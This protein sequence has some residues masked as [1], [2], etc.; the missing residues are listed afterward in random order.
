MTIKP[1]KV[2][3][4]KVIGLNILTEKEPEPLYQMTQPQNTREYKKMTCTVDSG[5]GESVT[6]EED[7]AGVETVP[8]EQS[9]RGVVYEVANKQTIPNEGEKRCEV[10]TPHM[11]WPKQLVFQVCKVHKPLLSVGKLK[12]AGNTVVFSK[13]HGNYIENDWTGEKIMMR[14]VGNLFEV[15][16]WVRV[17]SGF[18]GQGK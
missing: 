3:T 2:K 14:E 9:Q 8:S 11:W 6:N 7:C 12:R 10:T 4:K 15:D 13:R 16:L 17:S 1:K 18:T 5:A